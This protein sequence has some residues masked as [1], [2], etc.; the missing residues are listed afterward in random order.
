MRL[1]AGLAG[2]VD[3]VQRA[4]RGSTIPSIPYSCR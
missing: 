1:P 4:L 2:H 3:H